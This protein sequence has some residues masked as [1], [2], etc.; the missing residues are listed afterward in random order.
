MRLDW[1]LPENTR[2]GRSAT[3]VP[4]SSQMRTGSH[5]AHV[6]DVKECGHAMVNIMLPVTSL[7]M[8]SLVALTFPWPKYNRAS[9]GH[10]VAMRPR[11]P[12]TVQGLTDALI[13]VWK[14]IIQDSIRWLI[15]SMSRCCWSAYAWGSKHTPESH[16]EL[17]WWNSRSLMSLWFQFFNLFLS[18]ALHGLVVLVSVNC[19]F[20]LNKLY[21]IH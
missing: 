13:H 11:P 16:Y 2:I 14:E 5:R 1:H 8:P 17:P 3:A 12:Q 10:Y 21:S 6:T 19:D 7:S 18:T 9:M 20:V 4:F 15:R